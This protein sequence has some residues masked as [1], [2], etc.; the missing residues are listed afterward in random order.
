MP[1]I[2]IKMFGTEEKLDIQ[3]AA[4][5]ICSTLGVERSKINVLAEYFPEGDF[6]KGS[7]DKDPIIH[8]S[9]MKKNGKEWIQAL[10]SAAASAVKEQVHIEA[11][12][13]AVYAHL[14]ED[15]NIVLNGKFI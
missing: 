2:T 10:M 5:D 13:I 7:G 15:G 9:V 14:I 4:E 12:R 8:I 3:K 6:V 1:V 11:E